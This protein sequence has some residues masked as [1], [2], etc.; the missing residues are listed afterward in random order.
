[1][2]RKVFVSSDMGVDPRLLDVAERD[3][4]A[5]L[6]WPWLLASLDD[7]GRGEADPRRLK[8]TLFPAIDIVTTDVIAAALDLFESVG[9]VTRYDD[10]GRPLVAVPVDKWF[11]WQTHIRSEKRSNDTSR[12]PAPPIAGLREESRERTQNPASLHHASPRRAAPV[13]RN[14]A[15]TDPSPA[16]SPDTPPDTAP[17]SGRPMLIEQAVTL[18]AARRRVGELAATKTHPKRW[19]KAALD[20]IRREVTDHAGSTPTAS[21]DPTQMADALEPRRATATI[22]ECNACGW[23][24]DTGT[25]HGH[26]HSEWLAAD[27]H[28]KPTLTIVDNEPKGGGG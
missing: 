16:P 17:T 6:M 18:I 23:N 26:A 13:A 1:M 2:A 25:P 19:A 14:S 24:T 28:R 21:L 11:R 4:M 27:D 22:T 8:H 15:Q 3:P 7:W 12:Y 20:G 5:A 10:D 9:L